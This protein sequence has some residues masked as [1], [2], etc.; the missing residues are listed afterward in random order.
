MKS[1]ARAL[2]ITAML[3]TP[4]IA[5]HSGPESQQAWGGMMGMI[6]PEEMQAMHSHMGDMARLMEDIHEEKD[7]IKR[8]N[9]MQKHMQSMQNGLHMMQGIDDQKKDRKSQRMYMEDRMQRMERH[10]EMM[11]MMMEQMMK[12]AAEADRERRHLHGE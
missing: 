11:S 6:N 2:L 1:Y 9:L 4:A 8:D 10:M 3:S 7:S 12:H 5:H